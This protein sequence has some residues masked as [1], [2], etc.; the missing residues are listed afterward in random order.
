MERES[1]RDTFELGGVS[2]QKVV[3]QPRAFFRLKDTR[4][5]EG[6]NR[7]NFLLKVYRSTGT[8]PAG[9]GQPAISG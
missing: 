4:L 9:C 3:I 7:R 1:V 5:P 6:Q 8:D 2:P